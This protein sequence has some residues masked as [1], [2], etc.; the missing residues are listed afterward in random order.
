MTNICCT[1][2]VSK[3]LFTDCSCFCRHNKRQKK[4]DVALLTSMRPL[5]VM[6]RLATR[7][8]PARISLASR[9]PVQPATLMKIQFAPN[10][11][12]QA[13][14]WRRQTCKSAMYRNIQ[15]DKEQP[16]RKRNRGGTRYECKHCNKPKAIDYGQKVKGAAQN[17]Y[18]LLKNGRLTIY[19]NYLHT[20]SLW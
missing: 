3:Y 13:E 5:P 6:W 7:P 14:F 9:Q 17:L 20:L 15:L 10:T 12:G 8:L 1:F 4:Q 2:L 11:A 19:L 16:N 18:C